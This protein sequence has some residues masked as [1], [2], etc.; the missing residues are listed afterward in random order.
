[1]YNF[2][3]QAALLLNLEYSQYH[4]R[5][6]VR[7]GIA[8]LLACTISACGGGG[9]SNAENIPEDQGMDGI[10]DDDPNP[11]ELVS[12]SVSGTLS[13]NSALQLD[14]DVNDPFTQSRSNNTLA[15]AQPI[16]NPAII[17]GWVTATPTN[18]PGDQFATDVDDQ[19]IFRVSI[20][21]GQSLLLEIAD[22]NSSNPAE[23]DLDLGLFDTD[24]NLLEASLSIEN[25][26]ESLLIDQ[27]GDYLLLVD[28]FSG[29]SNYTLTISTE[30]ST[31]NFDSQITIADVRH[32]EIGLSGSL[33]D[34]ANMSLMSIYAD[35]DQHAAMASGS[36]MNST[37][38]LN[39]DDF[40]TLATTQRGATRSNAVPK[41]VLAMPDVRLHATDDDG[42][43]KLEKTSQLLDAMKMI[44]HRESRDVVTLLQYPQ[45]LQSD[46]DP[47]P[48]S[49]LQWNM[50]DIGWPAAIELLQNRPDLLVKT[51]VIAV[52][53]SGILQSHPDLQGVVIDQRDFV[54]VFFDGDGFDADASEQANRSQPQC[55]HFHGTHVSTTAVA[56]QNNIG[57]VGVA[58]IADLIAL[59]V[60]NDTD[61]NLCGAIVGDLPNAI[62]YAAGL[63]NSSGTTAAIPADVINL[64]LGGS[65]ANPD[66]QFAI[67]RAVDAGVIV[68]AAAGNSGSPEQ[69][70]P[71]A[72]DG[73]I[74]VAATDRAQDRAGY[75][76]FYPEVDI[77]APG[78][79]TAADL[80]A[81]GIGDGVLA[82]A[83]QLDGNVFLPS[84]DLKAGTSMASPHVAAG[85]ALMKGIAP[86]L[87]HR[88]IEMMLFRGELTEDIGTP[89]FDNMTGFGLMSLPKMLEAASRFSN[90]VGNTGGEAAVS[91]VTST[92]STLDFGRTLTEITLELVQLGEATVTVDFVTGDD[93][94]ALSDGSFPVRLNSPASADGFGVY[95]FFF[96]RALLDEGRSVAGSIQFNLSDGTVYEVNVSGTN[97]TANGTATTAAVFFIFQRLSADGLIESQDQQFLIDSNSINETASF[98][99]VTAGTYRVIFGTDTDNDGFL[100]DEGE[101]CGTLPVN[102]QGFSAALVLNEDTSDLT[103]PLENVSSTPFLSFT[104]QTYRPT[105]SYRLNKDQLIKVE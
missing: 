68:V 10:P 97:Q 6:F 98:T 74:A 31:T 16:P 81:D 18:V 73:V 27:T 35:A 13:A 37:I 1:M 70:F 5:G 54:D 105:S 44:N 8:I 59:K 46:S 94:L 85:I 62:L 19:D 88:D 48:S 78:G 40:I 29:A 67:Q 82:G 89:G 51:P 22:F 12:V 52:I 30:F 71:A 75:S 90:D 25:S 91:I 24:G 32:D 77:A 56:P 84:L 102:N 63:P 99:G 39:T 96:D 95:T 21:E 9:S 103:F 60:T 28:A 23:I 57:I 45:L 26:F 50:Y 69:S 53:D 64:S 101:I 49:Q 83:G 65:Q 34:S 58:P 87:T 79:D 43:D 3:R 55:Q 92:P 2:V 14:S 17:K 76:Q 93:E 38:K 4:C 66:E 61:E 41:S 47:V 7:S 36:A 86:N 20:F 100:C 33:T 15:T 104:D 80:N 11:G 42:N 72:F